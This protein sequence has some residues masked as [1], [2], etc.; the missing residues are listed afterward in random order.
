LTDPSGHVSVPNPSGCGEPQCYIFYFPGTG[1]VSNYYPQYTKDE[2]DFIKKLTGFGADNKAV[3][4][5]FAKGDQYDILDITGSNLLDE[6]QVI[7]GTDSNRAQMLQLNTIREGGY[8]EVTFWKTAE[9]GM[10]LRQWGVIP[11]LQGDSVEI[12]FVAHSGGTHIALNTAR[13]MPLV[14]YRVDDVVGLGGL[15]KAHEWAETG[16]LSSIDHFYDILSDSDYVQIVRN[17]WISVWP[18]APFKNLNYNA[19]HSNI[20]QHSGLPLM[21]PYAEILAYCHSS[22][23]GDLPNVTRIHAGRFHSDYWTDSGVEGHLLT[24]LCENKK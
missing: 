23:F 7:P 24:T 15:F 8:G 5:P 9:I 20:C 10:Q 16:S 13:H 3:I 14:G 18:F 22:G 6:V 21:L 19:W 2:I 1:K 12:D 11:E 4:F 17:G